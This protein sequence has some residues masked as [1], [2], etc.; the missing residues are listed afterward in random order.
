M[1]KSPLPV[2]DT[3]FVPRLLS[4]H[5]LIA[6]T[7]IIPADTN[8]TGEKPPHTRVRCCTIVPSSSPSA[9]ALAMSKDRL[10]E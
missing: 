5:K 3:M 7:L 1:Y 9:S 10:L 4:I 8:E 6:W 2:P